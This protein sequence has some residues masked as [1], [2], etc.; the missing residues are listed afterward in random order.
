M[1]ETQL[2]FDVVW[3]MVG[4]KDK[5]DFVETGEDQTP[6]HGVWGVFWV[7]MSVGY[8]RVTSDEH[9]FSLRYL[10]QKGPVE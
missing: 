2:P 1:R 9:I 4:F 8:P 3:E 7:V 6:Q 10:K 5:F